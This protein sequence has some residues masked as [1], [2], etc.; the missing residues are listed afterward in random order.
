MAIMCEPFPS[1]P[2][3]RGN[4]G[5]LYDA[6]RLFNF[7]G[8]AWIRE[9][10]PEMEN[11]DDSYNPK[12]RWTF[13]SGFGAAKARPLVKRL[14]DKIPDHAKK[15]FVIG[16]LASAVSYLQQ[17]F[18]AY[19]HTGFVYDDDMKQDAV[20]IIEDLEEFIHDICLRNPDAM[21]N[22]DM[23]PASDRVNDAE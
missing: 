23:E 21:I 18:Q 6:E 7:C 16:Q 22:K 5:T 11:L 3:A 1:H 19:E 9:H 4:I 17:C 14:W 8:D 10:V 15:R 2:T 20:E 13:P 12:R